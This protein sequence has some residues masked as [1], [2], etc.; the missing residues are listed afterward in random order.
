MEP[1]RV[2]RVLPGKGTPGVFVIAEEND[3][4]VLRID[5]YD[6]APEQS[7]FA[8]CIAW[9]HWIVIGIGHHLYLASTSRR[10]QPVNPGPRRLLR[11]TIPTRP[12]SARRVRPKAFLPRDRRHREVVV[13]GI[14][15]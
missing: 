3:K 6:V 8:E 1:V 2:G 4:P 12:L 13:P 7:P 5:V 11:T 9:K 14:G 15:N 10:R